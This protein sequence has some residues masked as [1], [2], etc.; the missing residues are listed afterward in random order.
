[1]K[2]PFPRPRLSWEYNTGCFQIRLHFWSNSSWAKTSHS[3]SVAKWADS[4]MSQDTGNRELMFP[5]CTCEIQTSSS[6]WIGKVGPSEWSLLSANATTVRLFP[7]GLHQGF[8][9]WALL[10]WPL[11]ELGARI[12]TSL[13]AVKMGQM[14]SCSHYARTLHRTSAKLENAFRKNVCHSPLFSY[15]RMFAR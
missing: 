2:R 12:V 11:S 3:S 15:C 1:V 4:G 10:T 13:A 9:V 8:N 6:S 5:C 14:S 7:V